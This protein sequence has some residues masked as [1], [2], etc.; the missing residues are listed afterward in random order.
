MDV[1]SAAVP[2]KLKVISGGDHTRAALS[3]DE[4]ATGAPKRIK[5]RMLQRPSRT[6]GSEPAPVDSSEDS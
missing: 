3:H 2:K 1:S 5:R 6:S 4:P